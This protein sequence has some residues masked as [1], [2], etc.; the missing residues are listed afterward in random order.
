MKKLASVRFN[1][2]AGLLYTHLWLESGRDS[3]VSAIR[4]MY[5]LHLISHSLRIYLI[6]PSTAPPHF[7]ENSK[8]QLPVRKTIRA[9]RMGEIFSQIQKNRD[10]AFILSFD[11]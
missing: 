8:Q 1:L 7:A 10:E 11:P 6:Y 2:R 3:A 4:F 9:C 5:V